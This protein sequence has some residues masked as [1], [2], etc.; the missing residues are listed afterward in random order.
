MLIYPQRPHSLLEFEINH[1]NHVIIA[2]TFNSSLSY[3]RNV[4]NRS[5]I[6]GMGVY[7]Y[8]PDLEGQRRTMGINY[9]IVCYVLFLACEL[10]N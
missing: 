3:H 1:I 9:D 2:H 10:C 6:G 4:L 5:S 8:I 7:M